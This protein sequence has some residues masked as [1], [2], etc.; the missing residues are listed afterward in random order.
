[1]LLTTIWGCFR[2]PSHGDLGDVLLLGLPQYLKIHVLC[3]TFLRLS[4]ELLIL[5]QDV[6]HLLA[7]HRMLRWLRTEQLTFG[8]AV[9]AWLAPLA[10]QRENIPGIY[11]GSGTGSWLHFNPGL[12]CK[13][14]V[15]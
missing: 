5:T 7:S 8:E 12:M 15:Y 10:I 2:P 11:T 13:P 6:F 3:L 14:L 9:N 1:M 4:P